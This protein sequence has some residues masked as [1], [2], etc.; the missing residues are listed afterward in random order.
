LEEIN[1]PRKEDYE[2]L[3]GSRPP[4]VEVGRL[5]GKKQAIRTKDSAK[6]EEL[7]R[8]QRGGEWKGKGTKGEKMVTKCL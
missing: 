5:E 1:K 6:E 8:P 2:S 7:R 4:Q 3:R